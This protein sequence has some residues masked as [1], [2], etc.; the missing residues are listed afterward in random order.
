MFF[1]TDGLENWGEK[2]LEKLMPFLSEQR[3]GK[4]LSF[5]FLPDKISSATAFLLLRYGIKEL[6]GEDDPCD[7][8][9]SSEGKPYLLSRAD[10]RFSLSHD[11]KGVGVALSGREIG[12]DVQEIFQY[13]KSLAERILSPR[14]RSV[15]DRLGP[16]DEVFTRMWTMKESLGKATGKGVYAVMEKTDFSEPF[17]GSKEI[18]GHIYTVG[19]K[20]NL[21]YA[22]C[23]DGK[24][25]VRFVERNRLLEGILR[26]KKYHI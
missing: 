4:V 9:F 5:R 15:F 22:V 11:R 18:D 23:S 24:E 26:F 14:E 17:S 16:D 1:L 13:E 10:V 19:K 2:E 7:F 12:A 8:G 3:K 25:E 20:D 6:T 21:C